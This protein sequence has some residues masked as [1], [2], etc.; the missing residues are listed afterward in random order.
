M[1]LCKITGNAI[2]VEKHECYDGK[3]ILICQPIDP[4]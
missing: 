2:A 1:I 3:K 4:S